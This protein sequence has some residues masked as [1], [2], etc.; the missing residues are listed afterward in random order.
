MRLLKAFELARGIL[1]PVFLQWMSAHICTL[2]VSQY[3]ADRRTGSQL[4]TPT[5]SLQSC[6]DGHDES[7]PYSALYWRRDLAG[8]PERVRDKLNLAMFARVFPR[9]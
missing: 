2:L 6:P 1:V 8:D 9:F 7:C 5:W 4:Q 3:A